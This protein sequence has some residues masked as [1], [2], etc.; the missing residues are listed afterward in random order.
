MQILLQ[1]TKLFLI[2]IK[3]FYIAYYASEEKYNQLMKQFDELLSFSLLYDMTSQ[4]AASV[5]KDIKQFY[6]NNTFNDKNTVPV[7]KFVEKIDLI[8]ESYE[9]HV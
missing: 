1:I 7:E 5:V 4:K 2:I 6:F 9:N 8:I 3:S